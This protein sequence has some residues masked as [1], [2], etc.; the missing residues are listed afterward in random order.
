VDGVKYGEDGRHCSSKG[1]PQATGVRTG[2]DEGKGRT[3]LEGIWRKA[4]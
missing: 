2:E 1:G 3:S 4:W